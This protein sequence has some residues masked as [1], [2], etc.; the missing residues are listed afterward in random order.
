MTKRTLIRNAV[1]MTMDDA[2]GTL[3]RGSV[4]IE[5]DRIAEIGENIPEA[6]AEVIEGYNRICMPGFIDTHR[7][8]WAAM[9]RGCSC[10]GDLETYFD[11][12]IFTFGANFTPEDSY[13]LVATWAGG[14]D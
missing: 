9:L 7:H 4:L 8:V 13:V 11:R 12:T 14:N 3:Q 10:L 2:L 5:G 1:V 6:G